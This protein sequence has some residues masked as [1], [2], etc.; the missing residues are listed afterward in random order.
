[1]PVWRPRAE[2]LAAAVESA[3]AQ[4]GC[5]LEL[6]VVDNG[7]DTPVATLLA[8]VRDSRLR[9]IRQEHSGVSAA[10]NAGMRAARG[11]YLRFLDCDD[12]FDAGST[13]HL[14]ALSADDRTIAYGATVYCNAELE[15]YKVLEC[16][17]Q[18]AL[19][20]RGL[21]DFTVMLPSLLFPRRVTE[22]A[23]EWDEQLTMC[24]D[25]DFVL[26]ALDHAVV[27]GD[28]RV[29]SYYRRHSSSAVGR[30]SIEDAEHSA[31]CVVQKY[32]ARHP[33]QA[34]S[35]HVRRAHVLRLT[36]AGTRYLQARSR[37]RAFAR[38]AAAARVDPVFTAREVARVV[39]AELRMRAARLLGR[40][41]P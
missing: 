35:S 40:G 17:L 3:L 1:M 37:A 7:N 14:L 23:G 16:S 24:E 36:S 4:R 2:W 15:P 8:D 38:Y 41:A 31:A 34:T 21:S 26:R 6:I 13:A 18:G 27:R 10:R 20:E 30:S 12:T 22:L 28:A 29:A 5:D 19:G 39:V 32:V 33:E 11:D 25:W 9:I